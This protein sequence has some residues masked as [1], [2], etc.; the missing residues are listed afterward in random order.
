VIV[1]GFV[2]QNPQSVFVTNSW[3]SDR[4]LVNST[5]FSAYTTSYSFVL[6]PDL[7]V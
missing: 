5:L 4:N 2:R 1:L 3:P 6:I 7:T